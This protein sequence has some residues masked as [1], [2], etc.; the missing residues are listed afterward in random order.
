MIQLPNAHSLA[1]RTGTI[2][3]SRL[4]TGLDRLKRICSSRG[5]TNEPNRF[6]VKLVQAQIDGSHSHILGNTD[7]RMSGIDR[8]R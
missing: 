8:N 2:S 5:P 3:D 1:G 6:S 7:I 4:L